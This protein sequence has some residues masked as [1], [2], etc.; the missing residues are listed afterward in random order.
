[1][2]LGASMPDALANVTIGQILAWVT[3]ITVIATLTYKIW[4]PIRSL[5][6]FL[7]DWSGKPERK[8]RA[9]RTIEEPEP[10]VLGRLD[11]MRGDMD[12]VLKQVENSHNT[13]FR[14][15]LDAVNSNVSDLS[16]KLDEHIVIS[17]HHDRKQEKTRRLLDT[18]IEST[19]TWT[20]MLGDLHNR[21]SDQ[22]NKPPDKSE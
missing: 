14:D 9:G 11:T 8:D 5:Q 22:Q 18:H 19:Q 1:M 12:R 4:G 16:K 7:R 6:T 10:G 13:N 3:G 20:D 15:D 21:W 2:T 17:K